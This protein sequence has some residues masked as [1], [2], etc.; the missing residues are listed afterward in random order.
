MVATASLAKELEDRGFERTMG[1][2]RGVDTELFRPRPIRRFGAAP[3]FLYVGRVAIEKNIRAF[4]D[5][6]LPGQKVVVGAGP[7]LQELKNAYP[8]VI[9]TGKK[10]GED[11]AQCYASADVFVM[12]SRTETFGIVLLEAMASGLPVAAYPVTGPLDLL[13]EG[14]T[15]VISQ[16]LG[17]AARTALK[18]DR[19]GIREK[20]LSYSW[21]GAARLFLSNIETAIFAQQGQCAPRRCVAMARRPHQA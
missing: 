8:Q 7:Q 5:L 16:D 15:G 17:E 2:T 14:E 3:V 20:S 1:W 21:D 9:F 12:P 6:E 4:L 10:T 11:L 13:S 19:A 18:L